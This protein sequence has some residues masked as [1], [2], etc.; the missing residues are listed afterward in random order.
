MKKI[1]TQLGLPLSPDF[2]LDVVSIIKPRIWSRILANVL[3]T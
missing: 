2:A 3:H 1:E